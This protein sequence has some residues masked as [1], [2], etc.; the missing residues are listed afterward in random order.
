M[1]HDIDVV[2]IL[3]C[4]DLGRAGRVAQ[5]LPAGLPVLNIDHHPDNTFFGTVN[6]VDP[7]ASSVCELLY[8]VS[9]ANGLSLPV[10]AA[11]NL[12]A[13]ILT[14]TGRFCFSNTTAEALAAAAELVRLGADPV[15]VG[16]RLYE[17]F[18]LGQLR[19]WAQ[20]VETIELVVTGRVAVAVITQEMLDRH[21]VVLEDTQEFA[22]IPRMVSGVDVGLLLR[23]LRGGEVKVSLRSRGAVDVNAMAV[24]L[25]GGG[26]RHAAG[27]VLPGTVGEVRGRVLAVVS[28]ALPE[29]AGPEEGWERG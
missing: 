4:P 12:F 9:R 19:L 25:G 26:H 3:D 1:P 22:E 21:G 7:E 10:A 14:D 28:Q 11:T 15:S 24:R 27:S 16:W 2:A 29:L 20:V 23:E 17:D 6:L 13:G 18:A 8:R 5:L